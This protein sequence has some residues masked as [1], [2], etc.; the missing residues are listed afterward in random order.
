M[1][2]PLVTRKRAAPAFIVAGSQP[3]RRE[4]PSFLLVL[5]SLIGDFARESNILIKF[6]VTPGQFAW[7]LLVSKHF[8]GA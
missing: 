2:P 5:F 3:A 6:L 4:L 7:S 1:L 8:F